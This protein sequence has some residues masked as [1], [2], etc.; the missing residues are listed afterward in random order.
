M[1]KW[2]FTAA[3]MAAAPLTA[4]ASSAAPA[5]EGAI[6]D[7]TEGWNNLWGHLVLDLGAI[8]VVFGLISIY[9]LVSFVRKSENEE[10]SLPGLS[11]GGSLAWTLVPVFVFLADDMYLAANGFKLWI[12][13]RTV[14]V[15]AREVKLTAMMYNWEFDYGNGVVAEADAN[16]RPQLFVPQGQPVVLRMHSEDVVHSFFLPDYRVK[17]DVM[18]GRITYEWFLPKQIG[19]NVLTCTEYCGV[20]H[21][22]MFGKVKVIPAAKF[23]EMI[24][25]KS[26][27]ATPAP[28]APA[29]G[30]APAAPAAEGAAAPAAPAAGK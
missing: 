25:A 4:M 15:N 16:G 8:G 24:L 7:H 10:G 3:M 17:E 19:E 26:G 28:A 21:S 6:H 5:A 30:A 11:L 9:M 20:G 14:P 12:N 2:V 22:N 1:K 29:E 18:P 13:Q 27:A 23:E